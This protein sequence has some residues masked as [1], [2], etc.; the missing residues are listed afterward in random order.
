MVQQIQQLEKVATSVDWNLSENTSKIIPSPNLVPRPFRWDSEAWVLVP[1][2]RLSVPDFYL[3]VLE[4]TG[5]AISCFCVV[6][7][8]NDLAFLRTCKTINVIK[9]Y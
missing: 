5:A 1:K 6:Y 8:S 7:I 3:A 4:E 9:D 2:A